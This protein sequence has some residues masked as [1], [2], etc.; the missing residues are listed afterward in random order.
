MPRIPG[1]PGRYGRRQLA[2]GY[3]GAGPGPGQARQ[4]DPLSGLGHLPGEGPV[5]PDR[6]LPGA[7]QA[8]LGRDG[9][10]LQGQEARRRRRRSALKLLPPSASKHPGP[11]SG[12]AARR[13][14]MAQLDHPNIVSSHDIG[15]YN[16]VHY[17]VMD[18]VEGHDLDGLVRSGG[19]MKVA[20]GGRLRHPGGPGA[21][22]GPRAGDRPPRH[23]AGQPDARQPGDRPGPRP[24]PGPDHRGR[25]H[26]ARQRR[27]RSRA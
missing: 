5:A 21:G 17:L 3:R 24:R 11:S 18:Y 20:S 16:G 25:R 4:A 14:I 8:G 6:A 9:D 26:L 13:Q 1:D 12:S 7:R 27:A 15:E 19:P 22:G 10:R 23:Q 2:D